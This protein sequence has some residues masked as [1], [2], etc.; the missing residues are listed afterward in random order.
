MSMLTTSEFGTP[1]QKKILHDL[2]DTG[3]DGEGETYKS[4]CQVEDSS[5]AYETDV[6]M[7]SPD[8]IAIAD[9]GGMYAR[10]EISNIRSKT[11]THSLYQAEIKITRETIEDSKYKQI[12][13]AVKMLGVAAKRTVERKAAAA[14]YNGFT[15]ELSPDG[16]AVFASHTLA[17]P[18]AGR[19]TTYSNKGTAALTPTA[20][21]NRRIQGRK[22]LDE[23]GSLSPARFDTLIVPSALEYTGEQILVPMSR[24]EAGT[25]NNDASVGGKGLKLVV[26]DWLEEASSNADTQW[27]LCDS[28]KHK[29]MFFWRVRPQQ[30][31]IYEEAT[32]AHLYRIRM[33]FSL[34]FSDYRGFDGS[35]G[36]A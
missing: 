17:Q 22:C 10:V 31:L 1:V 9:E 23:N 24:G 35:T 11:Y 6:Q 2:F 15:S 32:G 36:A 21:K 18:L 13:D 14:L 16:A 5:D 27:Y 29:F 28:K 12:Y 8:E 26:S 7:Q 34:G 33:R 3:W 25:A 20:L 4:I 30:E 19:P